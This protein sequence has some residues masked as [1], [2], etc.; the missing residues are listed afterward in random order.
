MTSSDPLASRRP[1]GDEEPAPNTNDLLAA[2]TDTAVALTN[3]GWH[4]L[5]QGE[6]QQAVQH[7][8]RALRLRPNY[9]RARS[10]VV[11][12]LKARHPLYRYLLSWFFWLARFSPTAQIALMFAAFLLLRLMTLV[13]GENAA[14]APILTPLSI[15]LF[16]LCV[17]LGLAS[18]LFDMLLRIDPVGEKSLNEDQRSGANLLLFNLLA[19]LPLLLWFAVTN[20]GLGIVACLF[21][22]FAAL[23]TSAIY[24]CA[25]GWPRWLMTAI[26]VGVVAMITPLLVGALVHVPG[27][28][29]AERMIWI[30]YNV[31]ALIASQLVATFLLTLRGRG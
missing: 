31:Y 6:P 21:L 8:R 25:A 5:E 12:A 10:G 1:A 14:W 11:E 16:A 3:Q 9:A 23:P 26:T 2:A 13:A 4:A 30:E 15:G 20:N 28:P 29:N 17:L 22:T 7:F 18:P 19:P 27:W 24:R